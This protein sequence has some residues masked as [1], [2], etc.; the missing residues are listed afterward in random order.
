MCHG[1]FYGCIHEHKNHPVVLKGPVA[2][3]I[4]NGSEA[5]LWRHAILKHLL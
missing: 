5:R 2:N 4:Y 3:N 1:Y